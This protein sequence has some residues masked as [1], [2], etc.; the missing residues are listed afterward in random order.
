M[1]SF[2]LVLDL[3]IIGFKKA[4]GFLAG[5]KQEASALEKAMDELNQVTESYS[6]NVGEKNLRDKDAAQRLVINA[7]ATHQLIE[8]TKK[9]SDQQKKAREEMGLLGHMLTSV[10]RD[11][12]VIGM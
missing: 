3:L 12:E 11:F 5:F 6:V 1:D 2:L 7:N 10:G 9:A 8:A 4:I